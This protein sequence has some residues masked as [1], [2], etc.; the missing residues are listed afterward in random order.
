MAE[1]LTRTFPQVRVVVDAPVQMARE[2]A[3]LRQATGAPGNGDMDAMLSAVAPHLG[4]QT[5]S[6]V[7]Y[8]A[9]NELLLKG[10]TLSPE[11]LEALNQAV[12]PQQLSATP[13]GSELTVHWNGG[14][15]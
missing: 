11:Q 3:L 8:N 13:S 15:R 9:P 1:V 2:V 5:P 6:E 14:G 7:G 12:A 4:G 10:V